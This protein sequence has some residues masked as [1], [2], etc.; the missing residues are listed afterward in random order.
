MRTH[1]YLPQGDGPF[2]TIV[3][4]SCYPAQQEIYHTHGVNLAQ[5]GYAYVLQYCRGTGWTRFRGCARSRLW[6]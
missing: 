5:R 2:P 4:R 3:Q 6:T 1:V